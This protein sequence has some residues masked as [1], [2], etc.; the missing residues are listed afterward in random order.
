MKCTNIILYDEPSTPEICLDG[1]VKYL[2]SLLHVTTERKESLFLNLD[3]STAERLAVTKIQDTKRPFSSHIPTHSDIRAEIHNDIK[4]NLYDGFE[5]QR[6]LSSVIDTK[7]DMDDTLHIVFTDR[8]T[9]TFDPNDYRYHARTWIGGNPAIISTT[10]MIEAPARPREFYLEMWSNPSRAR[11]I[12]ERY[13]EQ[14][15]TY[16][17][18][19]LG[20]IA[21]RYALQV[22]L[23]YMTGEAFCDQR[24]CHMYNAHWQ[25]ELLSSLIKDTSLCAKHR[26]IIHKL[27]KRT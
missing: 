15:L 7:H 6:V 12:E 21:K 17:D 27:Q 3:L 1:V 9:C 26:D 8:L 20:A 24:D 22:A 25:S 13:Q 4:T 19:R 18:V 16:H 14:F 23:Y 11:E 10:G 2:D 5:L